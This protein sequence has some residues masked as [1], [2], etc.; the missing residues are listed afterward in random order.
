MFYSPNTNGFYDPEINPT[1]PDDAIEI[2][3]QAYDDL[4]AGQSSGLVIYFD[5]KEPS[6]KEQRQPTYDEQIQLINNSR[7]LAYRTEADPLF[8]KSQRGE[9]SLDE[10]KSKV[11]E[12]KALY[13]KPSQN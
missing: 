7:S 11:A 13:P 1:I 6:L 10:W 8:F 4:I 9:C 5:G 2:T 12:I 3:Q